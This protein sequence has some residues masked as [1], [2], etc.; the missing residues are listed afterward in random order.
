MADGG[1]GA[2]RH[3]AYVVAMPTCASTLQPPPRP[4]ENT[5]TTPPPPHPPGRRPPSA[6]RHQ[7]R[8]PNRRPPR[9]GAAAGAGTCARSV[10]GSTG[11]FGRGWP[12]RR[13]AA[14]RSGGLSRGL[15]VAAIAVC[16]F[17]RPRLPASASVS[18]AAPAS[19]LLIPLHPSLSMNRTPSDASTCPPLSDVGNLP[20]PPCRRTGESFVNG[21]TLY[22][23]ICHG[24]TKW[25]VR[26]PLLYAI[27]IIYHLLS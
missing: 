7:P 25:S 22:R 5:P 13:L 3:G 23:G 14:D 17:D 18:G 15:A 26:A 11:G 19:P 2:G 6:I 21:Q 24:V 4:T 10:A 16:L 9:P 20:L 27:V 8:W 1:W 12:G